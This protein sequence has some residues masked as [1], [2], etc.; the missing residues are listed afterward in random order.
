MQQTCPIGKHYFARIGTVLVRNFPNVSGFRRLTGSSV[1]ILVKPF[2]VR[3]KGGDGN[4]DHRELPDRPV[5]AP[6]FYHYGSHRTDGNFFSVELQKS[7]SLKDYVNFGESFMI[8][9]ARIRLDF[10]KVHG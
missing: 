4:I 9:R 1:I 10:E 5:P 6:R 3:I 2:V 7:L 8:V